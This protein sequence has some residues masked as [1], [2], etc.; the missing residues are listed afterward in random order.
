MA[1]IVCFFYTGCFIF[2]CLVVL[3]RHMKN[4]TKPAPFSLKGKVTCVFEHYVIFIDDK[5]SQFVVARNQDFAATV[6]PGDTITIC[7]DGKLLD[8]FP[9]KIT[10]IRQ[11]HCL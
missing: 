8:T 5:G 11:L 1:Q 9:K 6:R 7:A 2:V 4:R 10:G 3:A